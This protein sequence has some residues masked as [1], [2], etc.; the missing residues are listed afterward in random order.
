M[1]GHGLGE[2]SALCGNQSG[3]LKEHC[4]Q[5]VVEVV[6]VM[7]VVAVTGECIVVVVV[8]MLMTGLY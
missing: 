7:V 3:R 2:L 8:V 1:R 5:V 4:K 6:V